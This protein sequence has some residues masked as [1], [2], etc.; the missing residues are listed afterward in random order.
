MRDKF[1]VLVE[2][3]RLFRDVPTDPRGVWQ[4]KQRYLHWSK[5]PVNAWAV[6]LN[7]EEVKWTTD[8]MGQKARLLST[9]QLR[10]P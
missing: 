6:A 1:L 4:S 7:D 5:I 3:V 8:Y 2:L 9:Q 10:E